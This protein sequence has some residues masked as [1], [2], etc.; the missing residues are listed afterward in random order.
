MGWRAARALLTQARSLPACAFD[1][2]R[3][4]PGDG[5]RSPWPGPRCATE[6]PRP[7]RTRCPWQ[8]LA[9]CPRNCC[10]AAPSAH[11]PPFPSPPF[12]PG[13]HDPGTL[14]RSASNLVGHRCAHVCAPPCPCA[15]QAPGA[16]SPSRSRPLSHAMPFPSKTLYS[17]LFPSLVFTPR[18]RCPGAQVTKGDFAAQRG[19]GHISA[20]AVSLSQIAG[21]QPGPAGGGAGSGTS[22]LPPGNRGTK[23]PRRLWQRGEAGWRRRLCSTQ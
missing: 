1:Q 10:F 11:H 16:H 3:P 4:A 18:A 23:R 13:W 12:S 21:Q 19:G 6:V 7:L 9:T 2:Q 5:S 8:P 14:P 20:R 15:A 17:A 22:Q